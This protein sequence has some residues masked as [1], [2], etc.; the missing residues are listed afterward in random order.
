MVKLVRKLLALKLQYRRLALI[1]EATFKAKTGGAELVC[2][3][4]PDVR[5]GKNV[6]VYVE[7]GS[8]GNVLRIGPRSRIEDDVYLQLKGGV[9]DLG[10]NVEIRRRTVLNVSGRF[11]MAG[12]NILSYSNVIHCAER[13][14]F[15]PMASTNEFVTVVDSRHFF[16]DEQTFFYHNT[17][18]APIDIG[19]NVWLANKS[20]VLMGV[21]I[22][23][24]AIVG[25]HSVVS[26]DVPAKMLVAG[27]PAKEIRPTMQDES[28]R[29]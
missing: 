28:A 14:T 11:A 23:D 21:T 8:K 26:R 29:S 27:S 20:S 18:S 10:T 12:D 19:A 9:I 16:T 6:Q 25:G 13:I 22:G 24:C 2:D 1:A 5:V 4:A 3:V 17:E 15:G 7:P